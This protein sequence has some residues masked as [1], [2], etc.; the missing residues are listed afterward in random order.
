MLDRMWAAHEARRRGDLQKCLELAF[1][2]FAEG[3]TRAGWSLT[4]TLLWEQIPKWILDRAVEW[5]WR[6]SHLFLDRQWTVE[7]IRSVIAHRIAYW[8]AKGRLH[9]PVRPGAGSTELDALLKQIRQKKQVKTTGKWLRG[10]NIDRSQFYACKR[11]G[12]KPVEG[13]VSVETADKIKAA[14][15]RD[16]D[17]LGL[18]IPDPL[19]EIAAVH[20]NVHD[21]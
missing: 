14:I 4:H 11:A 12:W 15:L 19:L 6:A 7:L 1:D 21:V 18:K 3:L 20:D 13:E 17:E 2:A 16:A 9:E 8:E 10:H 5:R